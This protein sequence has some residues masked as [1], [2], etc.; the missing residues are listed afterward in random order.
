MAIK[1]RLFAVTIVILAIS[2][3]QES[4]HQNHTSSSENNAKLDS[5]EANRLKSENKVYVTAI[6][7]DAKDGDS[8]AYNGTL[9]VINGCLFIDDMLIVVANP[10]LEWQQ[11]PFIIHNKGNSEKF[12]LGDVVTVGGSSSNYSIINQED[13]KWKN[14]PN[15]NCKSKRVWLTGNMVRNV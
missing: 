14:S 9:N 13:I 3:C 8:A 12:K 2:A 5:S 10:N 1:I 7:T 15:S 11:D 6:E 4:S